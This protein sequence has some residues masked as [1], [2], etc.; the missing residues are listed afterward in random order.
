M[1]GP[2]TTTARTTPTARSSKPSPPSLGVAETV[3]FFSA[4]PEA[5]QIF[6]AADIVCLPSID[7]PFGLVVLE[8]QSS[9]RAFVGAASGGQPEIVTNG[10]DGLLV[11]PRSPDAL[12]DALVR[13]ASDPDLRASLGKRGRQHVV[14]EF[15]EGRVATGFAAVYRAVANRTAIPRGA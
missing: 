5:P 2:I 13:L 10:D 1:G 7:E 8:A 4:R 12:A 14:D 3:R 11:P 6:A 9:G 15:P